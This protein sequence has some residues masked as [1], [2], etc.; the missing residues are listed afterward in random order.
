MENTVVFHAQRQSQQRHRGKSGRLA[1]R[2]ESVTQIPANGFDGD[3]DIHLVGP[4]PGQCG[5]AE[6]SSGVL[7][8]LFRGHAGMEVVADARIQMK[9]QFF[10]QF[11]VDIFAAE[12]IRESVEPAH[13]KLLATPDS[14]RAPQQRSA[15]T[16]PLF[17]PLTASARQR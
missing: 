13:H 10:V 2:A 11:V 9:P 4:L 6:S 16:T 17:P 8:G 15:E 5:I 7:L 1:Q 3:H 14:A 12:Q